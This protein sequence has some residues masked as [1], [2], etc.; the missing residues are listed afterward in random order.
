M[1]V[2]EAVGAD[3]KIDDLLNNT[4]METPVNNTRIKMKA[5]A[6]RR[7]DERRADVA[8]VEEGDEDLQ[9]RDALKDMSARC[10][11]AREQEEEAQPQA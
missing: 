6:G 1:L 9:S 10:C 4:A 5:D 8:G 3:D 2:R 11:R 7:G